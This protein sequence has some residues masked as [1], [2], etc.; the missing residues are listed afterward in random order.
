MIMKKFLFIL[1]IL[2][3]GFYSKAQNNIYYFKKAEI[4]NQADTTNFPI[5]SAF[6]INETGFMNFKNLEL[7]VY[8]AKDRE[9]LYISQSIPTNE[10]YKDII[11]KI[12]DKEYAALMMKHGHII[13]KKSIAG[14]VNNQ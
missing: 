7:W 12:I 8:D 11:N 9:I 3:F 5:H 4:F 13:D 10:A 2:S 6:K 1:L 14:P